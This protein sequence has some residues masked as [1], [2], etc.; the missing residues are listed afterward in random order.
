VTPKP[1]QPAPA[2][3][4]PEAATRAPPAAQVVAPPA[5]RVQERAVQEPAKPRRTNDDPWRDLHPAR[6]WPD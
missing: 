4:E 3:P 1:A 2:K 6:V 5:E